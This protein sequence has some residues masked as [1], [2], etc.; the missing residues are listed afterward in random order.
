MLRET[1]RFTLPLC[2]REA[3]LIPRQYRLLSYILPAF[4]RRHVF[5]CDHMYDPALYIPELTQE[6]PDTRYDY[7]HHAYESAA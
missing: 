3:R 4:Y 6:R 2:S 7:H 5:C 1:D